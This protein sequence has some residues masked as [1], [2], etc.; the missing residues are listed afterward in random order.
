MG[1]DVVDCGLVG[2]LVRR[3]STGTDIALAVP[4]PGE[5]RTLVIES[6]VIGGAQTFTIA[7]GPEG[8][9][10]YPEDSTASSSVVD[11]QEELALSLEEASTAPKFDACDDTRYRTYGPKFVSGPTWAINQNQRPSD[12]SASD[13]VTHVKAGKNNI[14]DAFNDCKRPDRVDISAP[15][16][17]TTN[18][19]T[20]I[21][22]DS[23]NDTAACVAPN[24]RD[25]ISVVG[26][27][28]MGANQLGFWCGKVS[29]L[30]TSQ[31]VSGDIL[32]NKKAG[33]FVTNGNATACL[34]KYDLQSLVTHEFRHFFGLRHV[35][36]RN[37]PLLTM[38]PNLTSCANHERTLGLGDLLGLESLY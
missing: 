24:S 23:A 31:Y 1:T 17:G 12:L 38:S 8:E 14:V 34:A 15:Y 18:V 25:S 16:E 9:I 3:Q 11:P 13:V 6:S 33:L 20:N 26:F 30:N 5:T 22:Y 21:Y 27:G 37:H 32:I 19:A 10:S 4:A 7:V 35:S 28:A 36:E 29:S 2:R